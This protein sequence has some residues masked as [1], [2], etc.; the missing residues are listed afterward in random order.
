MH[1]APSSIAP[2]PTPSPRALVAFLVWFFGFM[3]VAGEWFDMWQSKTWNGQDAA[4]RFY[5][6]VLAVLILLN[7]SDPD[8]PAGC[9]RGAGYVM[10]DR[11]VIEDLLEELLRGAGAWRPRCGREAVRRQLTLQVAGSDHASTMPTVVKGNAGIKTMMQGMIANFEVSDF[12]IVEMLI[13]GRSAAVR[14]Q[15]TFHYTKT[16]RI[17]STELAD[18]I[19]VGNGQVISF[20]EFLDTALAAKVLAAR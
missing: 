15:A 1:R 3:V 13:D 18:F 5:M 12:T 9:K 17:F 20:I 10:T 7:H 16:G 6:S 4:F 19:T 11:Q 14:W 8:L 2:R